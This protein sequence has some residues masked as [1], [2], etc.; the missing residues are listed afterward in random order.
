MVKGQIRQNVETFFIKLNRLFYKYLFLLIYILP[1]Y[2]YVR[3]VELG[4]PNLAA[5]F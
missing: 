5:S 4:I 2:F 3:A 1:D